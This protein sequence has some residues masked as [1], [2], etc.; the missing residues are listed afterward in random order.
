MIYVRRNIVETLMRDAREPVE[1][2]YL[3][4]G[5]LSG[6]LYCDELV[7]KKEGTRRRVDVGNTQSIIM[8]LDDRGLLGE[9]M[10]KKVVPGWAHTHLSPDGHLMFS[11]RDRR[12]Q[13]D[14]QSDFPESVAIVGSSTGVAVW[15]KESGVYRA[16]EYGVIE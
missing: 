12:T 13:R 1:T 8:D 14:F 6:D 15:R 5:R 10:D 7:Q 3:L 16:V 9:G 2:G 11:K 4:I